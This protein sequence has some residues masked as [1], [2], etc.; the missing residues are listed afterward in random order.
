MNGLVTYA[1][2]SG[3]DLLGSF[4]TVAMDVISGSDKRDDDEMGPFVDAARSLIDHVHA[5]FR[6]C[7]SDPDEIADAIDL[8]LV[9]RG[10][11]DRYRRCATLVPLRNVVRSMRRRTPSVPEWTWLAPTERDDIRLALRAD[12]ETIRGILRSIPDASDSDE[13]GMP[14]FALQDE[15]PF[16]LVYAENVPPKVRE[17]VVG[18]HVADLCSIA[19]RA[20]LSDGPSKHDAV[21]AEL[22][23]HWLDGARRFLALAHAGGLATSADAEVLPPEFRFTVEDDHREMRMGAQGLAYA[24]ERSRETGRSFPP[25]HQPATTR[26]SR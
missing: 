11:H 7:S 15:D 3:T 20:L 18:R 26:G 16:A 10:Y 17:A 13:P 8:L 24:S 21:I 25:R 12:H 19:V 2:G 6:A 23:R 22:A 9:D 1:L 4:G 14:S 5:R